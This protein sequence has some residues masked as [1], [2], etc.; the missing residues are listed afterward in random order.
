MADDTANPKIAFLRAEVARL[1]AEGL[2]TTQIA[3][4]LGINRETAYRMMEAAELALADRG[5]LFPWY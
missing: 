2:R 3:A 4:K 1:K 5:G